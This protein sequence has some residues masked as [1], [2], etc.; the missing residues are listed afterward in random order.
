MWEEEVFPRALQNH[1]EHVRHRTTLLGL[2]M[3]Q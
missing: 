3:P 1:F 2:W